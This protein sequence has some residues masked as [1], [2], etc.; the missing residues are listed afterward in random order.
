MREGRRDQVARML[1]GAG[2]PHSASLAHHIE[3]DQNIVL[4]SLGPR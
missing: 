4:A 3:T 1:R 2:H